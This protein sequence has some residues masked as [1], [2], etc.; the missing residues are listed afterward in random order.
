MAENG[1]N[2][3]RLNALAKTVAESSYFRLIAQVAMTLAAPTL[4]W[5]ASALWDINR[6]T[7][8]LTGR[9][10]GLQ[11]RIESQMDNRYRATDAERDFRLRDR[12]I[13][14]LKDRVDQQEKRVDM[15]ER[16][17]TGKSK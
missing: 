2:G 10:D 14:F 11:I 12:L 17:T 5:T 16:R 13:G 4:I 6:Q 9:I 1:E 7:A 8:A 15:L 3:G